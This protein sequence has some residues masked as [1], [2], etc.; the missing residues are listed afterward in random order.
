MPPG[1]GTKKPC[2][3]L[4]PSKEREAKSVEMIV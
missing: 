4:T 3:T 2:V 1:M